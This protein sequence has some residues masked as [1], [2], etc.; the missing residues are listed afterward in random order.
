MRWLIIVALLVL[1]AGPYLWWRVPQWQMRSVRVPDP[2]DR[3]DIEDNFRKTVG[4]ALAAIFVLLGVGFAYLQFTEQQW[5]SQQQFTAQQEASRQQFTSQ[6]ETVRQQLE[7][8]QKAS[9]D[10]LISNQVS[11]GFELFGS[12]N[13]RVRLGGIYA[14]GGVMNTSE[15]YYHSVLAALCAFVRDRTR[16]ATGEGPPTTDVQAALTVIGSR[17]TNVARAPDVSANVFSPGGHLSS[18]ELSSA[19]VTGCYLSYARLAGADLIDAYLGVWRVTHV[20]QTR[21]GQFQVTASVHVEDRVNLS[22]ADLSNAN[23]SLANLGQADLNDAILSA[24]NLTGVRLEWADLSN[25]K[26]VKTTLTGALLNGTKL[27]GADLT[28]AKLDRADLSKVTVSQ[29]QLDQACGTNVTLDPGLI[30][31]PC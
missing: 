9:R 7:E 13:I 1:L 11:K 29:T 28:G 10:L 21:P 17:A 26:L 8:Q 22:H 19:Q 25:A 30:V 2:K 15:Q 16:S 18:A 27:G 4:Q 3:A 20:S 5:N 6:Q 23:L 12:E 24:A 31:K 14:L